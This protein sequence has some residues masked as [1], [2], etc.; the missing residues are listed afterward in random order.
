MFHTTSTSVQVAK[1][2]MTAYLRA[3]AAN[4]SCGA[5]FRAILHVVQLD[6]LSRFGPSSP[7]ALWLYECSGDGQFGRRVARVLE[8]AR[9][10]ACVPESGSGPA[11]NEKTAQPHR[12]C[13]RLLAVAAWKQ[14]EGANFGAHPQVF[15]PATD[16]DREQAE[17]LAGGAPLRYP[18]AAYRAEQAFHDLLEFAPDWELAQEDYAKFVAW[19][20][21]EDGNRVLRPYQGI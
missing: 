10:G 2:A 16:G 18:F 15:R 21:G 13:L 3:V 19:R 14:A 20:G 11:K 1:L 17:K 8:E 4:P 12:D 9:S 6:N 5:A 7:A